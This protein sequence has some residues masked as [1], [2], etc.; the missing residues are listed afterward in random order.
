M[1]AFLSNLFS[2]KNKNEAIKLLLNEGGII[3]DVRTSGEFSTGHITGAKNVPLQVLSGKIPSLKKEGK[4]IIT[5][6]A[7][8]MR[9][10]SAASLL[11]SNGIQSI[12]GG[13]W[14]SLNKIIKE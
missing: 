14:T 4:P 10:A 6:C 7:S 5:C 11:K 13:S 3:L 1:F 9:S 8:G 2:N 12:N